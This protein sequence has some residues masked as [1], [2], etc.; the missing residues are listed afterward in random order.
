MENK[1]RKWWISGILSLLSPGLGHVY[2][3]QAR[4]GIFFLFVGNYLLPFLLLQS[5]TLYLGTLSLSILYAIILLL[6]GFYIVVIIDAVRLANRLKFEYQLKKYNKWFVYVGILVAIATISL[7]FPGLDVDRDTIK[8]NT[9]QAYKIPS[10]S[11]EP[12]LLIGDRILVDRRLSAR[13]P[14]RGTI[15]IFEWPKD[16][17]KDFVKRVEAIGGDTV[18]IRDKELYVNNKIVKESQVV[19]L[20]SNLIPASENPRDNYGP[21]TV[22]KDAYFVMGDNRDR[23][24]DSRF[25]GFVD[26]SKIKGTVK[27]LYWSWDRK[28][29]S[30][31]WNRIGKNIL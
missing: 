15:I 19:H 29:S 7:L 16:K 2:C 12:T 9:M 30:V 8:S 31:R 3:G 11:M 27:Q 10:G 22:P 4:K 6:L 28:A 5:I 17:T 23:A 25:W 13:N 20:E 21:V 24:Y 1:P 18:E 26:K 14:S